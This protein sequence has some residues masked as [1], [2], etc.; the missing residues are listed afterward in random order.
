MKDLLLKNR[1]LN[2]SKLHSFG[3]TE[4]EGG[5]FYAVPVAGGRFE[6]KVRISGTGAIATDL[7]DRLSGETYIL[8]LIPGTGGP[9]IS[10][11]REE[12]ESI[13]AS[14]TETCFD[15]DVFRSDQAKQILQYVKAKYSDVPEY[16]WPKFPDNA[17]LRRKDNSKWYAALLLLPKSKLGIESDEPVEIIDLRVDT[18][19]LDSLVDGR[20]Y[21]PGY[22]MNKKNWVTIC[23]D[24]SVSPEEILR[25]ID[26][27]YDLAKKKPAKR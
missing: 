2:I 1:R 5:Y 16:L 3:F 23:L 8:H 11:V 19:E 13:L 14:I 7:I 26:A 20:R 15:T 12:Y 4:K 22:H 18:Q 10:R 24:G 21:F 25:R 27:S 9:F 17:V 6:M